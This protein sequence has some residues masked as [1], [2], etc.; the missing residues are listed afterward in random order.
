MERRFIQVCR[1]GVCG[2]KPLQPNRF[3]VGDP[4][5]IS[6]AIVSN[7]RMTKEG[8]SKIAAFPCLIVAAYLLNQFADVAVPVWSLAR[9]MVVALAG[10]VLVQIVTS[11]LVKSERAGFITAALA[12]A[13]LGFPLVALAFLAAVLLSLLRHIRRPGVGLSSVTGVLNVLTGIMLILA[14]VRV[15]LVGGLQ[16]AARADGH[17]EPT[18]R[19]PDIMFVML[20]GYARADTLAEFGLDNGSFLAALEH[21]GFD[22]AERARSNYVKTWLTLAS[23]LDARHIK[24]MSGL[25]SSDAPLASQL[26]ALNT[27]FNE[28]R[29]WDVLRS[30]GYDIIATDSAFPDLALYTADRTVGSWPLNAFEMGL[31][32]DSGLAEIFRLVPGLAPEQHRARTRGQ[33]T[34]AG[35]ALLEDGKDGPTFVWAHVMSPHPPFVFDAD[36]GPTD[37]T[38]CYPASCGF[39]AVTPS[40]L[41]LSD[42]E[43]RAAFASQTAYLNELVLTTIDEV[44][45]GASSP[46]VIVIMSDHGTRYSEDDPA[47][48]FHSFL[49]VLTPGRARMFSEDAATV[50]VM[51]T[52]LNSYLDAD[53]SVPDPDRLFMS[54]VD[55][56]LRLT[57]ATPSR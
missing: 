30:R 45:R 17:G 25:P 40:Q 54:D 43:Y 29:S 21:R 26:R 32:R 2:K 46:P 50:M 56:A 52:I 11:R 39:F 28:A 33:L 35:R 34:A 37:L 44:L 48:S 36:G 42:A 3:T 51:A 41:G 31:I 55:D 19:E 23:M 8:P 1:L 12:T 13:A 15:I 27:V 4:I 49:A 10:V 22:V 53:L 9:P 38:A 7:S 6:E 16:S 20:D 14:I 5:A 18:G 47:E 57:E 24:D